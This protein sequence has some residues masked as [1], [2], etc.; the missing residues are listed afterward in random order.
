M[1]RLS[2]QFSESLDVHSNRSPFNFT[3]TVPALGTLLMCFGM[4]QSRAQPASDLMHYRARYG[5]TDAV[6]IDYGRTVSVELRH[7]SILIYEDDS[8][9]LMLLGN[10]VNRYAESSVGFSGLIDL[11]RLEAGTLVPEKNKYRP[12]P[13]RDIVTEK[14][15]TGSI[16]YDDYREKKIYF[17]ALQPGAR[18]VVRSRHH[19]KLPELLP[20]YYFQSYA[21]CEKSWYEITMPAEVDIAWKLFNIPEGAVRFTQEEK[22]GSKTYRWEYAAVPA[23]TYVDED[24]PSIRSFMPH[25]VVRIT[26]YQSAGKTKRVLSGIDDLYDWYY[27]FIKAMEEGNDEAIKK[28]V[29]SLTSNMK[30]DE[31]KAANIFRWVQDHIRYVAFE[32]G[33]QGFIPRPAA[34]VFTKRYGDC[35]DMT[36]IVTAMLQLAG[37]AAYPAW[38][39]T[40]EIPYTY[41]EVPSPL[42]DNHMIAALELNGHYYFLDATSNF[43][44]YD[45]PSSF[46]QGKEALIALDSAHHRVER[47]PVVPAEKNL[48]FD[49]LTLT[50]DHGLLKGSG[51]RKLTGYPRQENEYLLAGTE[52][53][54]MRKA[55][56]GVLTMG[57]NKFRLDSFRI[58]NQKDLRQPMIMECNFTVPDYVQLTA[59]EIYVNVN[60]HRPLYNEFMDTALRMFD[61]TFDYHSQW[62]QHIELTV[63]EGYDVDYLPEPEQFRHQRFGF[64]ISY[65]RV[66]GKVIMD[67]YVMVNLLELKQQEFGDWNQMISALNRAYQ[68]TIILKKIG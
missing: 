64:D 55:V 36:S 61:R 31:A 65:R 8:E 48:R 50:I 39:G 29:D 30:D 66:K 32:D 3:W 33:M 25:I 68:Q 10:N 43:L 22:D 11:V 21:P 63:P 20:A 59:D 58:R 15:L 27:G 49:S 35:K 37:Q 52:E 40:R 41:E 38:I 34:T 7:D 28:L 56:E 57:N 23:L 24:A 17:N 6:F 5:M 45:Y 46:I 19:V 18:R 12:E 54:T 9:D 47:V 62:R 44:P 53:V 1:L 42:A 4:Q 60:L 16:F 67:K 2:P 13:V 14:S 51:W 26:Q